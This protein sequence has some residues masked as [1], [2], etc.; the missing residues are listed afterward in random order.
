MPP[1]EID[2]TPQFRR[3]VRQ[4]SG[5]QRRQL[6][7]AADELRVTFGNPHKHGGLGIRRLAG[8]LYEFRIGRDLRVVF[9]LQGSTAEL[10]LVG[11]HDQIRTYLKNR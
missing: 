10:C 2:F 4:L 6:A 11:N 9:E 5:D 8:N 1:L 3:K 7:L